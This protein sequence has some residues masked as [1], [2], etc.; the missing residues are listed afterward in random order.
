MSDEIFQNYLGAK[1]ENIEAFKHF[2]N[3]VLDEHAEWRKS[4]YEADASLYP[5]K[6]GINEKLEVELKKFLERSKSSFPYFHPRYSAQMVKDP[7]LPTVLGYLSFMLSNP[8]NHAYEGGPV[9][10]EM[11]MEVVDLMLKFTG[12]EQGWG[13]LTSGGSLANMEALW[14]ARDYYPECYVCFSEVSHYSWKRICKILAI[15][16]FCEIPVDKNLR[17]DL[18]LLEKELKEHKNVFVMANMGSTGAGSIDN[19]EEI[20]ELKKKYNFHLHIDAAYGG[21]VRTVVLDNNYNMVPYSEAVPVSPY[22]YRQFSFLGQA[23][24]LTI[25]PHKHGLIS[26]GAGAVLY[27]KEDFRNVVLNTAPYTYHQTDKPNI[28]MFSLEGSRP[29]ATAAACYLTYKVLP[30]NQEGIGKMIGESLKASRKF[31]ELIE[32]S[33]QYIN[34]TVPDLDINCFIKQGGEQSISALNENSKQI[35]SKLSVEAADPQFII[36]KF[37]IPA[38]IVKTVLPDYNNAGNEDL[39]ALRVVFMKHWSALNDFYYV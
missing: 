20:L 21:F 32:E 19:I 2:I 24:S 22:T 36:S 12:F 28:G 17:M 35:Y 31:Y 15:K 34:L 33:G 39:I 5:A 7:S 27:K 16:D 8:N 9:T 4:F 6:A 37:V 11:E 3:V 1:A 10:T 29:G 26:Y 13:H 14:V 23:D 18:N 25:D 38:R 30:P